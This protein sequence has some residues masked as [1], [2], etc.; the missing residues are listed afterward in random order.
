MTRVKTGPIRK[1]KHQK[2]LKQAKGYRMSKR[3]LYK[4]AHE[5]VLHAGEYA[6]AG[7]RKKKG[8]FRTLWIQRINAGLRTIDEKMSYSKFI[9]QMGD[10]KIGVNRKMMA[11]LA[12]KNKEAFKNFV[13]F[14]TK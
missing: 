4:V 1:R 9:K 6:F 7:R 13:E 11:L 10:K 12:V 2:V 3:K 5:A 8:Q 14:V